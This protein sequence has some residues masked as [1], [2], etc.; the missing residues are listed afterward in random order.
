MNRSIR[1]LIDSIR[2]ANWKLILETSFWLTAMHACCIM[3]HGTAA[4]LL[5]SSVMFALLLRFLDAQGIPVRTRVARTGPEF[6]RMGGRRFSA[7]A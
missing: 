5:T 7:R 2:S 6:G 1:N 3:T 4:A